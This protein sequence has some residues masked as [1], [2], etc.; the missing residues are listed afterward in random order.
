MQDNIII[1]NILNR[2]NNEE[3]RVQDL[4][5]YFNS[6]E[7]EIIHNMIKDGSITNKLNKDTNEEVVSLTNKGK[8]TLFTF[9]HKEE[10]D[11][12]AKKLESMGYDTLYLSD[13]LK[14]S[15]LDD[16]INKIFS[17]ESYDVFMHNIKFLRNN[18]KIA[19]RILINNRNIG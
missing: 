7:I 3:I 8:F 13:Y 14:I 12:Y 4:K 10:I 2:M 9:N 17:I 6:E 1:I 11:L 18:K 5:N 16:D 15:N 19:R